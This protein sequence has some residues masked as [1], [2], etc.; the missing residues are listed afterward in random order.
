MYSTFRTITWYISHKAMSLEC[1]WEEAVVAFL[2]SGIS[3]QRLLWGTKKPFR[4]AA[5]NRKGQN[6]TE[7]G[8]AA[9]IGTFPPR[10]ED[11]QFR[12]PSKCGGNMPTLAAQPVS[13]LFTA[14]PL[15]EQLASLAALWTGQNCVNAGSTASIGPVLPCQQ[16]CRR[17]WW[18]RHQQWLNFSHCP[19]PAL[20][21]ALNME[22]SVGR[23]RSM[24][25]RCKTGAILL[26]PPLPF[27][28]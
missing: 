18:G 8:H 12:L 17:G 13:A 9:S 24:R 15:G 2:H 1:R 7:A 11:S 3:L 22:G 19:A 5:P 6:Q 4:T 21:S 28:P 14:V 20:F 27:A 25:G 26:P 23:T 16:L 10:S